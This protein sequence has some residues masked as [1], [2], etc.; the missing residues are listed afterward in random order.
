MGKKLRKAD[1]R[2]IPIHLFKHAANATRSGISGRSAAKQFSIDQATFSRYVNKVFKVP[3]TKL[4]EICKTQK[5]FHGCNGEEF[6][7]TLY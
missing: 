4:N 3:Q 2:K 1:R 5:N 7:R 6:G